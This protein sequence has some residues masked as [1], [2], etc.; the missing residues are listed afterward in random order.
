MCWSAEVSL[1]TFLLA[2]FATIIGVTNHVLL[3]WS[4][5]FFMS[6][7]SIQLVEFFL[8]KNIHNREK[9][10]IWSIVGFSVLLLQPFFSI[11]RL[12]EPHFARWRQLLLLGYACYLV[13]I[14]YIV[15]FTKMIKF[16]S[17]VA[18]NGHLQWDFI[19]PSFLI[20]LPWMLLLFVPMLLKK[21]YGTMLFSLTIL[22]TSLYTFWKYKTWGTMWCWFAAIAS[23]VYVCLGFF[24]SGT[25]ASPKLVR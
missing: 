3:P 21:K 23:I 20:I 12:N 7:V 25:C 5:V 2:S 8:W 6:F 22:L 15:V 14:A 1:N 11:L 18:K 9:N 16:E 10:R 24:S 17:R 19:P 13:F 4:A